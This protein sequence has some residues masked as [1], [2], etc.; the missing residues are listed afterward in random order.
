MR[1]ERWASLS[2][3]IWV[4]ILALLSVGPPLLAD[5]SWKT[6]LGICRDIWV[7]DGRGADI[8]LLPDICFLDEQ[9]ST[10]LGVVKV[11]KGKLIS[12]HWRG[13]K[14]IWIWGK[15]CQCIEYLRRKYLCSWVFSRS[16]HCRWLHCVPHISSSPLHHFHHSMW[17]SSP[18]RPRQTSPEFFPSVGQEQWRHQ[19]RTDHRL[20]SGEKKVDRE[21]RDGY[22]LD[23]RGHSSSWPRCYCCP[24]SF[25]SSC[26]HSEACFH[27][28]RPRCTDLLQ[29]STAPLGC[30][31][32]PVCP[33]L[34]RS[35]GQSI[36]LILFPNTYR[37]LEALRWWL[38]PVWLLIVG[39][40][41]SN[42]A[43]AWIPL[44]LNPFVAVKALL[45][46]S[47]ATST[48]EIWEARAL[49]AIMFFLLIIIRE[50]KKI[51]NFM[52]Y[53]HKILT[54]PSPIY[55]IPPQIC[56]RKFCDKIKVRQNSVNYYPSHPK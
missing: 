12:G 5:V 35:E 10:T 23:D 25:R 50:S 15:S 28:C 11:V 3:A 36:F 16:L 7:V 49:E 2:S 29:S 47:T 33:G 30:N 48:K 6:L 8:F 31:H 32:H 43:Q 39:Q 18:R 17:L 51:P 52:I 55:G 27:K 41:C 4:L 9:I 45:R 20:L 21:T 38:V 22:C 53:F 54:L 1:I 14:L 40:N 34:Q 44:A 42:P 24:G 26:F 46:S 37:A 13:N 19:R 56:Y